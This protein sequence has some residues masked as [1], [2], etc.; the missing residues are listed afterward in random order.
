MVWL[1]ADFVSWS[2]VLEQG[3]LPVG[4]G[5]GLPMGFCFLFFDQ[6]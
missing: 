6:F 4:L 3:G 2:L 5:I 1:G